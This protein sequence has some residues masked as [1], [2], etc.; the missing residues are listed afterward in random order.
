MRDE[1]CVNSVMNDELN[2]LMTVELMHDAINHPYHTYH[3]YHPCGL[4]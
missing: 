1:G 3:P 2:V 4:L